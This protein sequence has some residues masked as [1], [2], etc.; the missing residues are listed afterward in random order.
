MNIVQ[1]LFLSNLLRNS[2]VLNAKY[3]LVQINDEKPEKM[4]P[5]LRGASLSKA[6]THS[7]ASKRAIIQ[8][9]RS[10]II[11]GNEIKPHSEP[12]LALLCDSNHIEAW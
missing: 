7:D 10:R 6:E 4:K 11:G 1:L 3:L 12:W 5:G 2:V 8:Y 9:G